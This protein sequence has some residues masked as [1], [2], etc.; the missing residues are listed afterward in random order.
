MLSRVSSKHRVNTSKILA[1]VFIIDTIFLLTVL[2]TI[3]NCIQAAY[4]KI[5]PPS[6][7]TIL[8]TRMSKQLNQ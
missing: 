4:N 3:I 2:E 6:A 5:H 8:P 1:I 7:L